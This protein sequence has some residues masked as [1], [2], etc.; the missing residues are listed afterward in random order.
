MNSESTNDSFQLTKIENGYLFQYG[1]TNWL[2]LLAYNFPFQH[3]SGFVEFKKKV[4]L[5]FKEVPI[6]A[7]SLKSFISIIKDELN[8]WE[9]IRFD[10]TTNDNRII[11]FYAGNCYCSFFEKEELLSFLKWLLKDEYKAYE[12]YN[13]L[14]ENMGATI[15]AS[16][17]ELVIESK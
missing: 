15:N 16:N 1:V 3:L 13:K 4:D 9:V 17:S 14:M 11:K 8:E 7:L 2:T 6:I 10:Y 12:L 5:S